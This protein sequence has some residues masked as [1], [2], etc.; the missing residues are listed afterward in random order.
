MFRKFRLN[1]HLILFAQFQ[2]KCKFTTRLKQS[3]SK[4]Q[5]NQV[6]HVTST[7]H[8][9]CPDVFFTD[10]FRHTGHI[11]FIQYSLEDLKNRQKADFRIVI[12][13]LS[14]LHVLVFISAPIWY[15]WGLETVF[16]GPVCLTTLSPGGYHRLPPPVSENVTR[17]SLERMF[18][19]S[20]SMFF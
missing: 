18:R 17:R 8:T 9:T 15:W 7:C 2:Y 12:R 16:W 14:Q 19:A 10:Q 6:F 13:H 5:I 1:S 3:I 4:V 11:C 20:R